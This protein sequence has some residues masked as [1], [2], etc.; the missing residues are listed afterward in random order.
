MKA[1]DAHDDTS[2]IDTAQRVFLKAGNLD[3]DT[4]LSWHVYGDAYRI[5]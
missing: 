5:D 2:R 3:L 4:P 1:E